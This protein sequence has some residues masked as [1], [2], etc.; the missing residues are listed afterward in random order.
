MDDKTIIMTFTNQAWTWTPPVSLLDLF[1]QS[2]HLGVRMA[3]L[4]IVAVS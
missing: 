2:F 3:P 4:I 1:L